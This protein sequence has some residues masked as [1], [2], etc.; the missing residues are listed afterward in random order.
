MLMSTGGLIF[1]PRHAIVVRGITPVALVK[2]GK[3][4]P[5]AVE[6]APLKYKPSRRG[7]LWKYFLI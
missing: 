7:A 3:A 6:H 5:R 1:K 4:E 2:G